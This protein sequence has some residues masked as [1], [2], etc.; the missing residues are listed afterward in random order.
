MINTRVL[1]LCGRKSKR[2]TFDCSIARHHMA[3]I[4]FFP[5]FAARCRPIINAYP[6]YWA[7]RARIILRWGLKIMASVRRCLKTTGLNI[8]SP[9]IRQAIFRME[10]RHEAANNW[11][12]QDT[13]EDYK[14]WYERPILCLLCSANN[15]VNDSITRKD[16]LCA[17]R[18]RIIEALDEEMLPSVSR[19]QFLFE[20]VLGGMKMRRRG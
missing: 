12:A 8:D 19:A 7:R 11:P 1:F 10:S 15:D 14:W 20:I 17:R 18:K 5:G 4:A 16:L 13:E 9:S 6:A 3:L 2:I